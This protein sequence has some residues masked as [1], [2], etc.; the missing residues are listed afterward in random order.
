MRLIDLDAGLLVTIVL[1]I[2]D[3]ADGEDNAV[4]GERFGLAVFRLQGGG[5]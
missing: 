5:E 3:D 2:A 1:D 4:D